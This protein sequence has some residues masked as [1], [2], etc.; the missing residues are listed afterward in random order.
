M[1][2]SSDRNYECE[3]D[4]HERG[5]NNHLRSIAVAHTEG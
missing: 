5:A 1:R 4:K 3:N 2:Q